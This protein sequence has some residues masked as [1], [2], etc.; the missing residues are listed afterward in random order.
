M[1]I[2]KLN[3]SCVWGGTLTGILLKNDVVTTD[4]HCQ[5]TMKIIGIH[6]WLDNLNSLLPLAEKLINHHPNYEICLYDG[7]GHGFSSHIPKGIDYSVVRNLQDLRTVIQS[8]GWDK[9]KYSIIGHS[10]GAA[11]GVTYT[12]SYP[13]EVLCLVCLDSLP[14]GETSLEDY[15]KIQ[16]SRIDASLKYH[17]RPPRSHKPHLTSEIILQLIKIMRPGIT[18]E[19]AKLLIERSI[20]QDTGLSSGSSFLIDEVLCLDGEI[21]LTHD[22]SLNSVSIIRIIYPHAMAYGSISTG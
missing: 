22:E 18:D 1:N 3:I 20:R 10:F 9:E 16:G 13:E 17:K 19:A 11:I 7:A 6:G 5:K 21:H 8:L 4:S 14:R 2:T 12:A 15:F